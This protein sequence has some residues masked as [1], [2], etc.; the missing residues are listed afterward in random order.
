MSNMFWQWIIRIVLWTL[1]GYLGSRIMKDST[2]NGWLGNVILGWIGGLIGN[3]AFRLIGF[4]SN[5]VIAEIIVSVV[6][7]CLVIWIVR[8]FNLGRWF[9]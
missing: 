7:A 8:R 1:A 2:P 9:D 5:G 4:G 3:F 6:G